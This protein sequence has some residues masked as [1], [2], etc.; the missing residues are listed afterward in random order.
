M[1]PPAGDRLPQR[2]YAE[3]R[4]RL[5]RRDQSLHRHDEPGDGLQNWD[6]E[7]SRPSREGEE[8]TRREIRP[9]AVSRSNPHEW[10]GPARYSGGTG[11]GLGESQRLIGSSIKIMPSDI[12]LV[13]A[14]PRR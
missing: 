3:R 13:G 7:N 12:I 9:P 14:S 5:H 10:T 8:T 4:E 6:D 2:K 1:D 11:G